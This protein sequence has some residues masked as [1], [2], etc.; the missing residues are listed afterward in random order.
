M[1]NNVPKRMK[2]SNRLALIYAG[3]LVILIGITAVVYVRYNEHY[4]YTENTGNLRQLSEV[5]MVQI[6]SKLTSMEQT[7]VDVLADS[8]FMEA[9]QANL[10]EKT[11]ENTQ[12]IRQTLINAYKNKSDIRRVAA[13][14]DAGNYYCTGIV[15]FEE[16]S[17]KEKIRYIQENYQ[18][19]MQNTRV[20]QGPSPDFWNV[21]S[22]GRVLSEIKPI[23]NSTAEIIGYVEVQQNVFYMEEI[24][25]LVQNG[26]PLKVIVF[27]G[28]EDEVFF[29]NSEDISEETLS[30]M[31]QRTKEY[32]KIKDFPDSIVCTVFSNYYQGRGVFILDK[33]PLHQMMRQV[34]QGMLIVAAALLALTLG[35]IILM[36]RRIFTP[37]NRL[38]DHMSKQDLSHFESKL[39]VKAKDYETAVLT[40]TYEE[41]LQRL[42][43]ASERQEKLKNVQ[44]KTL[45]SILQSE[46]SPHFLYNTLGGI[47]NMC[48]EGNAEAAAEACYDLSDILRYSSDYTTSEV[49]VQEEI[50]NLNAYMSVMKTRYRQRLEYEIIADEEASY[51]VIPKLTL[52]PLAENGIKYSLLETE[53]VVIK[54]YVVLVGDELILEVKDNGCGISEEAVETIR[55]RLDGIHDTESLEQISDQIQIGGMGLSGTLIRLAIFFGENFSYQLT[56]SNDEDGTTIVIKIHIRDY[57]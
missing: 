22:E 21:E 51:F 6:D 52:Q 45:F 16:E 24:C 44:T 42:K 56:N 47:A 35:F 20:F 15:N 1:K 32:S 37:I 33:T 55:K 5:T 27:M 4:I 39:D 50:R 34:I 54:I 43:D 29:Q 57:R 38:V 49:T 9:W 14:D 18:L 28:D 30:E 19:N 48:E 17:L 11:E 7:A 12:I 36:T 26:Y 41:M 8:Q 25:N 23:K 2:M 40:Q 53:V 13:F 10:E 3:L 46:I 31:A